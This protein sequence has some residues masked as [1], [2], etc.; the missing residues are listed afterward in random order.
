MKNTVLHY[1]TYSAITICSL[2]LMGWFIFDGFSYS[3]Q[4][5]I[6][7]ASMIISLAFVFFGIKHYRDV[8]NQGMLSFKQGLLIGILITLFASIAFGLLDMIYVKY[9]NPD[10]TTEYYNYYIE[11]MRT[12]LS[13]SEFETE[14]EKIEAQKELFSNSFLSFLL[15]FATV[16]IIG[17]IISLISGLILQ[18]KN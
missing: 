4:E 11:K 8:E 10:F 5:I 13:P 2:F 7:Y 1:S 9:I 17:F 14:L 16:F 6:G 18:R 3:F 12:S 15:M